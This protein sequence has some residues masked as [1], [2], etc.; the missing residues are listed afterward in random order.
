M[1][2][3]SILWV[4]FKGCFIVFLVFIFIIN[5]VKIFNKNKDLFSFIK[6][7]NKKYNAVVVDKRHYTVNNR[8]LFYVTFSFNEIKEEYLV[9]EELYNSLYINKEGTIYLKYDTFYDFK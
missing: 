8:N 3:S 5:I 4:L 2:F 7:S 1:N 6:N 9:S